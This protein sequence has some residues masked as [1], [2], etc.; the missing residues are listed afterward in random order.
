MVWVEWDGQREDAAD[1][2]GHKFQE[3]TEA[4]VLFIVSQKPNSLVPRPQRKSTF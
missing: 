2:T 1:L 3:C 4:T